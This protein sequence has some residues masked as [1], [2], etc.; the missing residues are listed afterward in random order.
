MS[1]SPTTD[2]LDAIAALLAAASTTPETP[3][4]AL[5][6][7]TARARVEATAERLREL[8]WLLEVQ[9]RDLTSRAQERT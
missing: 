6:L 1:T 9:E 3:T 4:R 7:A 8:R 5:Y 2:T